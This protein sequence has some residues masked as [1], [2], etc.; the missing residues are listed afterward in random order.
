MIAR[1]KRL[2]PENQYLL[3]FLVAWLGGSAALFTI[4]LVFG[5]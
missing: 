3:L 4:F 5:R 2:P 1:I